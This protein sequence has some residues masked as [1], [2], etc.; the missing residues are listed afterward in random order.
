VSSITPRE[1]EAV[2]QCLPPG[3]SSFPIITACSNLAQWTGLLPP[4][5]LETLFQFG[6]DTCMT[7]EK[8]YVCTD[9]HVKFGLSDANAGS[10]Y[11]AWPANFKSDWVVVTKKLIYCLSA[12]ASIV[13]IAQNVPKGTHS[14]ESASSTLAIPET[15]ADRLCCAALA[16]IIGHELGH[17]AYGHDLFY[18]SRGRA[19]VSDDE[20]QAL[21]QAVGTSSTRDDL[22]FH[23][24]EL[25]ADHYGVITMLRSYTTSDK[26]A[27]GITVES[28][29]FLGTALFVAFFSL[30]MRSW[31]RQGVMVGG[32]HP[33][34][35]IRFR[36]MFELLKNE[37]HTES[38]TEAVYDGLYGAIELCV[39]ALGAA[40]VPPPPE[41][42]M[43]YAAK[44]AHYL[45]HEVDGAVEFG[46]ARAFLDDK[47][48]PPYISNLQCRWK[49]QR[50]ECKNWWRIAEP[51]RTN[52]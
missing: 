52:C 26:S 11:A 48:I 15:T 46:I 7:S 12:C 5:S 10:A 17:H 37:L 34:G 44:N 8:S 49:R 42:A 41:D 36:A 30:G 39:A 29:R 20:D 24:L 1:L 22:D 19:R 45:E 6:T 18:T 2:A 43:S 28:A 33:M 35:A 9:R 50:Q 47:T 40:S 16:F 31:K 3:I 4:V 38:T 32:T 51:L 23:A 27:G 13:A 21:R 14:A 25:A